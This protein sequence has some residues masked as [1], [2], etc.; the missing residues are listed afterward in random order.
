MPKELICT[1]KT[2]ES[3]S[4]V[5]GWSK[6]A[7]KAQIG[8]QRVTGD[9]SMRVGVPCEP[10]VETSLFTDFTSRSQINALI[11]LLKQAR[12]DAFGR[13]E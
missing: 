7:E 6:H 3:G 1:G 4:V 12:D 11:R 9:T 5:V 8:V 10:L 13:D 2:G